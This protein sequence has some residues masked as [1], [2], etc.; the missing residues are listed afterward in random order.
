MLAE[1]TRPLPKQRQAGRLT[2]RL[3]AQRPSPRGEKGMINREERLEEKCCPFLFITVKQ[4]WTV[5]SLQ[6][7][8]DAPNDVCAPHQDTATIHCPEEQKA[9]AEWWAKGPLEG[10][11]TQTKNGQ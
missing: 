10:W 5:T 2:S 1:R 8:L 9:D 4:S 11:D 6:A 7:E 3:Q